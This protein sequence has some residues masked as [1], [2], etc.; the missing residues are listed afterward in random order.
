[1]RNPLLVPEL[2][3]LIAEG[4]HEELA[5]FA[6]SAH[7]ADVADFIALLEPVEVRKFLA[8]VPA[9]ERALI[10]SH[11]EPEMESEL[12]ELMNR[13]ELAE[14][15]THMVSDE[16]VDLVNRLPEDRR[17]ALMPALA[18]SERDDILRLASYPEGSAGAVMSSDY[19][20]L[21]PTE[22]VAQALDHLRREAPDKETIYYAYVI[23]DRRRLVGLVSLRDLIL[24]QPQR[25]IEQIM[26]TDMVYAGA[27]DDQ[28][29]VAQ[30]IAKYDLIALPVVGPDRELIG[31]VTHDD[32]IDIIRQE[33]TEDLE[34]LM[35][36]GG[37]HAVAAYLR[38]SPLVHF[39]NRA[40]WIVGLAALGLVSGLILHSFEGVL[41]H[42]LLLAL[43]MPMIADTGGNT[44]S[45]SA[46]VVIRSLALGEITPR[47]LFKVLAKELQ[48]S[49]MLAA[50]LGCL[51]FGK[52]LF[53]SGGAVL[54]GGL[55]ITRLAAAIALA[56]C[57][58][59]V[60]ATLL[61]A[62]LPMGV[63]RLK[64]DPAVV[65]SPALTTLV[66]ISGLL[67][68]FGT[69]KAFLGV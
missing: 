18:Q 58:Q 59:V 50:V 35:G 23:D 33:Q 55:T 28:E 44:G 49:L 4:L 8:V 3:E 14:M 25:R 31:I 26:Q 48:I 47:D 52:V 34:K 17:D 66:D 69:A 12:V 42:L 61:G 6:T 37:R 45:Q 65:A 63:S 62:A 53:L 24:S 21:V 51:A 56:L 22:T 2:R 29:S 41:Q 46:T 57:A 15:V 32:A 30:K 40:G 64:L 1:M 54:P 7:P 38:T 9:R 13:R 68:Y 16:R 60:S 20:T 43:Y 5:D 67:I 19:A 10:F 39:R 27:E 36:I 11:L